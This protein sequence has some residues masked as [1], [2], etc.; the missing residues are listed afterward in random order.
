MAAVPRRATLPQISAEQALYGLILIAGFAVRIWDVGS[1]AMHGDEAVHAWLAW[2]LYNGTGY[3]YDPVYHGPLQF[4]VTAAFYFLFGV[5]NTTGRLM[6]VLFGTALIGLPYFFRHWMGRAGALGAALYIAF[7][8]AFVYVSRLERDDIFTS[9]FAMTMALSIFSY[10]RTRRVRY[11]YIG[12]ASAALSLAAMENTYITYFVFGTFVFLVVAGEVA[13][14]SGAGPRLA[15]LWRQTNNSAAVPG[16]ALAVYGTLLLA[17]FVLT[18]ITG[19]YLPVPLV[20]GLG[21]VVLVVRQSG[22]QALDVGGLPYLD[23]IRSVSRQQ[24]LNGLT[25]VI[26]I[27]FLTF[28]SFGSNLRGIWDATQPF[29]NTHGACPTNAYVLNPC[30]KDIIGGLFYWLSQHAV[31]RG[32]QPWYYYSLLYGLYEQIAVLLG[33]G[34]MIWFLRR[35]TLFTTFLTYWAILMFGVYSWAGEKFPWLMIHPLMPFVLLAAMFVADLVRVAGRRRILTLAVVALLGL[36]ELHSL[37]EVNFVNGADP[38]EMMVYVQSA[39]D[40]PKVAQEIESISN[41]VTN[42]NTLN[43][44][45]DTLDTWPFAWY[46]RNMPNIGY[47]SSSELLHKPYAN[48]PVII[49]DASDQPALYPQLRGRYA[50]HIYRLRWWFP[51]DGYKSWTWATFGRDLL[52]P[53]YWNVVWKWLVHRRPFGPKGAVWFYLYVKKG[54]VTPL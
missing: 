32:G 48:N 15:G 2:N 1:R 37:Y 11:V 30:R 35:P 50:G 3:Q 24:W 8:P 33:I 28:S 53:G 31:A 51:E 20:L 18:I 36:V 7:S 34:G 22:L 39:P 45:I 6:A 40:T 16:V 54:L 9:F 19:L 49:V 47:P 52:K 43:V 17:A 29:F 44:T 21:L 42:G 26:A 14:R 5:S 23:A 46:L 25:I 13:A 10:L 4:L 12:L 38:V 27:L 41:K